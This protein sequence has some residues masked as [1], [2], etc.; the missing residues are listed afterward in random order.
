MATPFSIHFLGA[1]E[2]VTGSKYLIK[3]EE[4]AVMVDCGLFQ[5]LKKLREKNWEFPPVK[6]QDI[7]AIVLTHGH[8]DHTGYLPR[9]GKNGYR[10]PIYATQPT[11]DIAK[12]ILEDSAK[13]QEEDAERANKEGYSKH[14]PAEPLYTQ[15]D[16]E[17][18][19]SWMEAVNTE[20]WKEVTSGIRVRWRYVGHILGATYLEM[21]VGGKR[22]VFSGDV[23]RAEDM[24]LYPPERPSEAD[25]LLLESTYG[26][27]LH[28]EL[29]DTITELEH[30]INQTVKEGGTV[31]IPSFA[32]ERAQLL[33]YIIW[34]L[35]Q[36]GDI[37]DIPMIMDSPMGANVLELFQKHRDWHKLS[38]NECEQMVRQFRV[39][40]E[41]KET[42][43]IRKD[44][45]PKIIIAGSGMVTGG[46]IL[47]YL[48]DYIGDPTSHLV[49]AGFQAEGTRGRQLAE[50]AHEIK[51][52]GQFHKVR[53]HVSKLDGLSAHADQSE[54]LAWISKITD[55]PE[56]VYIVHG[57]PASADHFRVKLKDVY[58]WNAQ[59]PELYQIEEF[60]S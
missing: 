37:P 52:S 48:E 16:V 11:L 7:D 21:E 50:G 56:K 54:L 33:M 51:F 34:Q 12:I 55:D 45:S 13:I 58:G 22:I 1:A 60:G 35:H 42:M 28:G 29:D 59:I 20:E 17:S 32:V 44:E 31:L 24:M 39:V 53:L 36:A 4:A 38:D 9:L 57:E 15:E 10:G 27:R 26:D 47:S 3:T 41:Y 6:P 40:R 2:T 25:I 5:G 18:I 19:T 46:R 49:L 14:E 43:E 23:G 8:L 30:I